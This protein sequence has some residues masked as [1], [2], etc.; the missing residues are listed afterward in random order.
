MKYMGSKARIANE[1]IPIINL[2]K[3]KERYKYIEPFVGGANVI[4]KVNYNEK[5]G[6]DKNK[7]LIALLDYVSKGNE[8][9]TSI[10]EEVYYMVRDNKT[11]Y[12]D[13]YVGLVGF[14]ASYGGRFFEGYPR[15]NDNKGKP[16]DYTNEAIR[17]IVKQQSSLNNIQFLTE[18]YIN[19]DFS[20]EKVVI[21]CD[22]PYAQSKPYKTELL[23]KFNTDKFWDTIC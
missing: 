23:G 15:G 1:I 5:F 2:Y 9:P 4:D 6:Y 17:N 14:C 13:W 8:L 19:L 18:D 21:Y 16:R 10:S 7:Y 3:S 20:K 11:D 12:D 22:P